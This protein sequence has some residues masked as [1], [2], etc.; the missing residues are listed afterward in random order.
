MSVSVGLAVML[1]CRWADYLITWK[2]FQYIDNGP[3]TW[4]R[5]HAPTLMLVPSGA[6][7]GL[8]GRRAARGINCRL[9]SCSV[10]MAWGQF[11][12]RFS[13]L[14]EQSRQTGGQK[15]TFG[16]CILAFVSLAI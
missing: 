11:D 5:C 9:S 10:G 1:R 2:A 8:A 4:N 6:A 13:H 3:R 12:G 16:G 15:A 7:S 14:R